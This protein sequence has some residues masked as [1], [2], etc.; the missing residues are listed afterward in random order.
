MAGEDRP[1]AGNLGDVGV[2]DRDVSAPGG[3]SRDDG[4]EDGPLLLPRR[5]GPP[6]SEG[7]GLRDTFPTLT[8]RR[9]EVEG[10]LSRVD[11]AE[12]AL[13]SR[14]PR[15]VLRGVRPGGLGPPGGAGEGVL[16]EVVCS[17]GG[18]GGSSDD[19]RENNGKWCMFS[20]SK[21]AYFSFV[22]THAMVPRRRALTV[23]GTG[24]SFQKS[25]TELFQC[26]LGLTFVNRAASPIRIIRILLFA[27]TMT[28]IFALSS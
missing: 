13:R 8:D 19:E 18:V 15:D 23:P 16:R 9:W 21:S 28:K 4:L 14:V 7:L 27:S 11:A 3:D 5:A 24:I 2:V 25:A 22:A 10:A 6:R 26:I 17:S 12:L 20:T 1:L